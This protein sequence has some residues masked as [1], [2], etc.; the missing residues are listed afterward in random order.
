MYLKFLFDFL[1]ENA[2]TKWHCWWRNW[3][4]QHCQH[5][6]LLFLFLQVIPN[7]LWVLLASVPN[8]LD[9]FYFFLF[10]IFLLFQQIKSVHIC[11]YLN[12]NF[13]VR[14]I[15]FINGVCYGGIK[16][17]LILNFRDKKYNLS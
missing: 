14:Y 1:G 7:F 13:I 10:F 6:L 17:F 4:G 12:R 8:T 11:M 16:M 3:S 15:N 2:E 9:F 5:Q